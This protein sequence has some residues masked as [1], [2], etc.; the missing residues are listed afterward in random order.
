VPNSLPYIHTERLHLRPFAGED[1]PA[2]RRLAGAREIADTTLNI[3][4]PYREGVAEQWIATHR[5]LFEQRDA[6]IVAIEVT[7]STELVGAI[8]LTLQAEHDRAELGYWIGVPHWGCGYATEAARALVGWGF[9]N[10]DLNR[11]YA[12][13]LLRNPQSGRVM[14]K[15]GMSREGVLRQYVKK[16]G[17]YEDIVVRSILREEFVRSSPPIAVESQ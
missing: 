9:H 13:H 15:V 6:T 12:T 11:I 5:P 3:P 14:E 4:H 17:A 2:V 16:W 10:L 1:A 7:Q 8:G